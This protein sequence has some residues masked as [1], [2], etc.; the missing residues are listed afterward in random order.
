MGRWSGFLPVDADPHWPQKLCVPLPFE[1]KEHGKTPT[2]DIFQTNAWE[3][4]D[5]T[6]AC[7]SN[8]SLGQSPAS[9]FFS[10]NLQ[11]A[12]GKVEKSNF[13]FDFLGKLAKN[14]GE[15]SKNPI[16]NSIFPGNLKK[17]HRENWK[18]QF[19]IQFSRETCKKHREKSK[20]PILNSIFSGN[21]QKASRISQDIPGY[22]GISPDIPG[23]PGIYR[24][25]P[26]PHFF[27]RGT[28]KK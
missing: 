20:N 5:A 17:K 11:K 22:P 25:I 18:I 14:I 8:S 12:L 6:P 21:L 15:K 23:Y 28:V 10:G 24:D 27:F 26:G 1:C 7:K 4:A 3:N 16:L 19:W 9:S 13:E 2:P